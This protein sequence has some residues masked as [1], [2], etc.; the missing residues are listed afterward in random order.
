[1]LAAM[2]TTSGTA[3]TNPTVTDDIDRQLDAYLEVLFGR[4]ASF[5]P[6]QR[7]AIRTCLVPGARRLVVQRTGWG[8]SLVYW[9]ATRL[10]RNEGAG[11][12]VVFSP[13]L[14]LMRNQIDA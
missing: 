3:A 5:H 10:L 4:G 6:G 1:M 2:D 13:L 12:T 7:E 8:K 9:L 11:P 14:S